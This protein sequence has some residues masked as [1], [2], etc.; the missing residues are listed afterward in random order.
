MHIISRHPALLPLCGGLGALGMALLS[1]YGFGTHPCDLCIMQRYPYG[2]V[3][4]LALLALWAHRKPPLRLI[5]WLAI[6][7]AF[8]TTSGIA[9]Y[10]FGVEQGWVA[11][12][13]SCST[14]T[15]G[16]QDLDSLRAQIMGAPLVSCSD[17]GAS[18]L[19]LSMAGWNA[20]YGLGCAL[21]SMIIYRRHGA[22]HDTA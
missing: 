9:S 10:H 7:A 20:F 15:Q 2:V 22:S 6:I 12:P 13:D 3:A 18:F 17:V 1:Q 5:L 21:F 4:A 19:G 8:L 14:N 11:G 16:G